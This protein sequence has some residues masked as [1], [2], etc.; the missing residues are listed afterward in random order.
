MEML[1]ANLDVLMAR[2]SALAERL[3]SWQGASAVIEKAK[4]GG[5]A[6]RLEGRLF[7]SAYSPEK[8][9]ACEADEITSNKIKPDWVLLFGLG[10]GHLL[11]A[12]LEKGF[13]RV[14]VYEPS[15]EIIVGVLAS[16]DLSGPLASGSVA[17]YNDLT[18]FISRIRELDGFDTKPSSSLI[19]DIKAV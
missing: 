7:H 10:C 8:E 3:A 5:A 17:L 13:D 6:F 2:N 1:G 14:L 12:V 11:K 19:L 4:A 18:A 9:A 15:T 16:V